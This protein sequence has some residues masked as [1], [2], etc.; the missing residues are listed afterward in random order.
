ML[1][2]FLESLSKASLHFPMHT[3]MGSSSKNRNNDLKII[4]TMIEIIFIHPNF[5]GALP[6]RL[7]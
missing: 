1:N 2:K 6:G 7:I 3:F 5:T 4:L